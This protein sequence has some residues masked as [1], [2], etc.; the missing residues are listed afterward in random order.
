MQPEELD[1]LV[2]EILKVTVQPID[3]IYI[4]DS[5]ERHGIWHPHK[6]LVQAMDYGVPWLNKKGWDIKV[7]LN[8]DGTI[9]L[10]VMDDGQ[11]GEFIRINDDEL[12]GEHSGE[13]MAWALS[14]VVVKVAEGE[15]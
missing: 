5:V 14:L 2:A 15:K 1:R 3:E 12:Q 10:D 4:I 6:D 8:D 13:R 7:Y 9:N 11:Y